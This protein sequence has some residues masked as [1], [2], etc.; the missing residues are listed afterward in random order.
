MNERT[1]ASIQR[2]L[3]MNERKRKLKCMSSFTHNSCA[4]SFQFS[5]Q[6]VINPIYCWRLLFHKFCSMF[7]LSKKTIQFVASCAT[8]FTFPHFKSSV[9]SVLIFQYVRIDWLICFD[10]FFVLSFFVCFSLLI[11][12]QY[13]YMLYIYQIYVFNLN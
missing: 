5:F 8:L 9:F 11:T 1:N 6:H 2:S 12:M 7:S 10:G 3:K 13:I 4:D